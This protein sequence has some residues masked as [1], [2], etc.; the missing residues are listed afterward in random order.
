MAQNSIAVDIA[1]FNSAFDAHAQDWGVTDNALYELCRQHP[2]HD[3]LSAVNAKALL[4][5]RGF[6]TGIERHIKSSGAQGSSI[7]RLADHL[8]KNS[9]DVDAIIGRLS[10]L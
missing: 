3:A 10:G 8:H 6:A 5:G 1:T 7:G 2:R 4:I 9:S